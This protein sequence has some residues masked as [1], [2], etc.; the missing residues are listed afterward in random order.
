MKRLHKRAN[1]THTRHTYGLSG[2]TEDEHIYNLATKENRIIITQDNDFKKWIKP[3]QAGVIII[4]PYLSTE[5]MDR[6]LTT[7]I[8]GKNPDEFTG[9]AT[10][11]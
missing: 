1:L 2:Q 4:P 6:I 10:K 3:K 11:I 7:F 9:K 5:E 8:K